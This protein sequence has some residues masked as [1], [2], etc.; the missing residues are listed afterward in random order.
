MYN[1]KNYYT[2]KCAIF[3][4]TPEYCLF[5]I[6]PYQSPDL[7]RPVHNMMEMKLGMGIL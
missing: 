4:N 6:D 3:I 1:F 2:H 7:Q 5:H